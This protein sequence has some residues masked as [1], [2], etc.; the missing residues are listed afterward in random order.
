MLHRSFD[1][2][3]PQISSKEASSSHYGTEAP[4]PN[5]LRRK[6]EEGRPV[7]LDPFAVGNM[8][9]PINLEDQGHR[10]L[11]IPTCLET[12]GNDDVNQPAIMILDSSTS[13]CAG[14]RIQY[15]SC[16]EENQTVEQ[17][18]DGKLAFSAEE[19]EK[20]VEVVQK[21]GGRKPVQEE[22]FDK[23]EG[24]GLPHMH[25]I[26][27]F[28]PALPM[29]NND[30]IISAELPADKEYRFA[31]K[32]SAP[33]GCFAVQSC[34]IHNTTS[35]IRRTNVLLKFIKQRFGKI[36]YPVRVIEF[37]KRGLPH[38][39]MILKIQDDEEPLPIVEHQL[40]F[41]ASTLDTEMQFD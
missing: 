27:K 40:S 9:I 36:V 7:G 34:S 2:C 35:T 4:H 23:A 6:N 1:L 12:M 16:I 5:S 41:A 8:I 26:L 25:M 18:R 20:P 10:I 22:D 30:N 17:D 24:S 3:V 29:E 28:E 39:R 19:E 33:S 14:R 38:M 37:Q 32:S 13:Y 21:D 31:T 11:A 15:R